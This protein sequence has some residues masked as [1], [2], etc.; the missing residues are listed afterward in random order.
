M[1]RLGGELADGICL[2][3]C[4]PEQIAW[5]RERIA[6]GAGRGGRDPKSVQVVEY[7]RVCV[8]QD[9][10][11]ARRAFARSTMGYALG[12]RV[13]TERERQLGYRGHFERMGYTEVL[14]EL[15]RMRQRGASPNEV[16][17]AFPPELLKRVGY[18]GTPDEAAKAFQRLAEGLDVAIVRVVAARPG[19]ASVLAVLQACRPAL[20][21]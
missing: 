6:E 7:I 9:V 10:E 21:L 14:A 11:V 1:L 17:D 12:Q 2:N 3:W 19:V 16:A 8:D 18:Y 5:S 15:D 20:V 13:P 4:T